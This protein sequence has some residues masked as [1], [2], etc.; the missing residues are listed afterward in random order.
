VTLDRK[1]EGRPLLFG[2]E[3]Q[4]LEARVH[5]S[6]DDLVVLS[7]RIHDDAPHA[8]GAKELGTIRPEDPSRRLATVTRG[9]GDQHLHGPETG[10]RVSGPTGGIEVVGA[11]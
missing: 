6:L 10:I 5:G 2:I 1:K 4:R 9:L 7:V 11:E 3:T 8:G